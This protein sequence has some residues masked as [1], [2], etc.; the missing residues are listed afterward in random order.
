M[1]TDLAIDQMTLVEGL[2][3]VVMESDEGE[4]VRIALSA[5]TNTESG[6]AYLEMN[7]ITL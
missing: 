2:Y 4:T 7:P 1:L 3:Q 5:L 6:R